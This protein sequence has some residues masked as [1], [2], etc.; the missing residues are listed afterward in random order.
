[1]LRLPPFTLPV[2]EI[3]PA[4]MLPAPPVMFNELAFR[5]FAV[6]LPDAVTDTT[7]SALVH[8]LTPLVPSA[9]TS[10]ALVPLP[11]FGSA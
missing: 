3:F 10:L 7:L 1:M 2:A 11:R 8:D 5:I 9:S 4:K 6:I